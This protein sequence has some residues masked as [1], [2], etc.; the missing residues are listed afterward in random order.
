MQHQELAE[1]DALERLLGTSFPW[2]PGT[3]LHRASE[4]LV[5]RMAKFDLDNSPQ[6]TPQLMEGAE[7]VGRTLAAEFLR[8]APTLGTSASHRGLL[9]R[10]ATDA[11]HRVVSIGR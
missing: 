4:F 1:A 6:F 7:E 2:L 10:L 5:E 3:E 11:I 8:P 9:Q